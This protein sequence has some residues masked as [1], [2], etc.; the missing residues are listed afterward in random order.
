M[1]IAS[2]NGY[3]DHFGHVQVTRNQ[4]LRVILIVRIAIFTVLHTASQT[5]FEM[6]HSN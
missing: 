6:I 1:L 4:T 3:Y 2:L 5:S